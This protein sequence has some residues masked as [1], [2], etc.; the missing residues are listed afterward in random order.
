VHNKTTIQS[1]NKQDE[2]SK[3]K[4]N[5]TKKCSLSSVQLNYFGGEIVLSNPLSMSSYKE[6]QNGL[7]E[8]SFNKLTKN[9]P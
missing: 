9:N 8:I 1:K 5:N 6:I 2:E 4:D 3:R 7:Q